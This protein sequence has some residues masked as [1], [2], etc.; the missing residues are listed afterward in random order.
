MAPAGAPWRLAAALEQGNILWVDLEVVRR[1][2]N[3]AN[4]NLADDSTL[5]R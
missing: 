4:A 2:A 1:R 3:A 5:R